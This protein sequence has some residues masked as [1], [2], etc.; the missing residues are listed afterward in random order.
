MIIL[1]PS[2]WHDP[3]HGPGNSQDGA[4]SGLLQCHSRR[5]RLAAVPLTAAIMVTVMLSGR[6]TRHSHGVNL[7]GLGQSLH[8]RDYAAAAEPGPRAD[9]DSES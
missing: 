7:I 6:E 5:L 2:H 8:Y 3:S 4:G 1:S 9:S